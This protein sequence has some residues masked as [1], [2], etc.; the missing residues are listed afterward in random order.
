MDEHARLAQEKPGLFRFETPEINVETPAHL[1]DDEITPVERLFVRNT[2]RLP[3]IDAD[4]LARWTLRIDGAVRRPQTWTVASLQR[5]FETVTQAATIECAGNGRAFFQEDTGVPRWTHGAAGCAEWTG[6]RLRDLLDQCALQASAVYTGHHAPDLA[7]D[8]AGPALSRGLP[9]D[10]ALAPE[11]MVAWAINGRPLPLL[12]G[13]PLRIVAPG[14]PGSAWQKWLSRIEIRD[15]EHD[16]ERMGDL[17]YRL[18][19]TPLRP[20]EP[21][22]PETFEVITDMPVRSIITY[23]ADGFAAHADAPVEVRGFAWSG[24]CPVRDVALSADGG[25]TWQ[26]AALAPTRD[27]FAWR[28]FRARITPQVSGRI[29]ILARA[30]DER[31]RTQPLGSA[32]WNPRGYC[33]NT[34]H[35]ITG[36]AT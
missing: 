4:A 16:G 3:D 1:L 32:P 14:Y 34:A 7:I 10:K 33:N 19:R 12:H 29:E 5:D 8:G 28:R 25:A 2:G 21:I 20:G 24:H 35:R 22:N 27:R 13:S 11:T 15:R 30:R 26:E 18:P 17:H 9:I 36:T 6:V 23:P 31:G